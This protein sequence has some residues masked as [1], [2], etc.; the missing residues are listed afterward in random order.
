LTNLSL[1]TRPLGDPSI[2][3]GYSDIRI[4]EPVGMART[5]LQT[6]HGLFPEFDG[7][8]LELYRDMVITAEARDNKGRIAKRQIIAHYDL[9]APVTQCPG[10]TNVYTD[11]PS[12][13]VV[14]FSVTAM[15][16]RPEPIRGPN[17]FPPSGS[18]FPVGVTTVTCVASDYCRNTNTCTFDVIVGPRS[19]TCALTITP[20]ISAPPASPTITVSW[21]CSGILQWAPEVTGPWEDIELATSPWLISADDLRRF[22]RLKFP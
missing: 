4:L 19:S 11:D 22:Y 6:A 21:D 3:L 20:T 17:C 1:V 16:D 9:T 8:P 13:E 2:R 14:E 15:D 12:G 5:T 18:V 7:Q 10:N